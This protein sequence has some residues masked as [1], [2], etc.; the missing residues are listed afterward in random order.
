MAFLAL[1]GFTA[2]QPVEGNVDTAVVASSANYPDAMLGAPASDK[3]GAPILLTD[4]DSLSDSTSNAIE[5]LG[6]SEVV[7]LG[8]PSVISKNVEAEI[9]SQADSSTR[10]WGVSGIGTSVEVSQYFWTESDEA[11]I[12][13][14]PLE[15][16]NA[17]QLLSAV[18]NEVQ[19]EDEPVLISKPGTVSAS[20]LSEVKRL[21][22]S[23]VEVYSTQAVNVTQDLEDIGVEEVTVTEGTLE[24][25]KREAENRTQIKN[26]SNLVVIAS[27]NFRD[28]ISTPNAA[29]GASITVNSGAEIETAVNT[30]GKS[31]V[32]DIKVVGN[33]DLAQTIA[34]QIRN[35][36]GKDV[37]VASG[38]PEDVSA[39]Q[40][41]QHKANWSQIQNKRLPEW[42][43]KVRNSQGLETAANKTL[44]RAETQVSE[45]SS[46]K[47]QQLLEGAKNAFNEGNFFEARNKATSAISQ[48]NLNRFNELGREGVRS[49]YRSEVEDLKSAIKG[50]SEQMRNSDSINEKLEAVKEAKQKG[51]NM[52]KSSK[53]E[54]FRNSNT[55]S[56][57]SPSQSPTDE[58]DSSS[59]DKGLAAGESEIDFSVEGSTIHSKVTFMAKNAG[60]SVNT[61]SNSEGRNVS[62]KYEISSSSGPAASVLTELDASVSKR[63]LSPGNYT[64]KAVVSVD[65][66]TVNTI[67]QELTVKEE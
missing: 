30:A 27:K 42:K 61:D 11:T 31:S 44:K 2:A 59:S 50:L 64:A 37:E 43:E 29:N 26:I 53:G 12:V 38:G 13:Q 9:N 35:K 58:K 17:Y 7:I 46:E 45:N 33:N 51:M 56:G 47:A 8:G 32:K 5:N 36:T 63:D 23:E 66:G 41:Q 60:Y 40:A 49:E 62:F 4:K 16:E 15:S 19:N 14:Y 65:G 54:S 21:G 39:N 48:S 3:I 20:T 55:K 6:V 67:S 24:E 10:L 34:D 22:A 52:R 25:V 1:I 28:S 57:S 18:K